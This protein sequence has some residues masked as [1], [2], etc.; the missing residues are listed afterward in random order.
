MCLSW[1]AAG[2]G[3]DESL[4]RYG[5]QA[6]V[7]D[8]QKPGAQV[9]SDVRSVRASEPDVDVA[10]RCERSLSLMAAPLLVDWAKE[11]HVAA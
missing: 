5:L 11:L 7:G 9:A 10:S 4:H 8:L 2:A 6:L 3:L 1:C